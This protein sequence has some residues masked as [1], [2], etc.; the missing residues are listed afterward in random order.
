M[1]G[2]R[3]TLWLLAAL[4]AALAVLMVVRSRTAPSTPAPGPRPAPERA[5]TADSPGPPSD[6]QLEALARPRD[7]PT[8]RGRNPFEFGERE[9]APAPARR[10]ASV[11][12]GDGASPP[13]A[14][15]GPPPVAPI[16][17]KFIGIVT[18]PNGTRIAVLTDGTRPISGE[19]GDEIE[20]RYRILRIGSESLEIAYLD[21][22]GRQTLRLTGQ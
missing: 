14:P 6:V 15:A 2:S 12:G 22:R 13:R 21:G 16:P 1:A 7:E 4:V 20:G 19:E 11:F 9:R 18:K 8:V 3:R 17:L 5:G 10:S